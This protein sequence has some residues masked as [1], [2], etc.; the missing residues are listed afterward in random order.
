M[1]MGP[2]R[3]LGALQGS[4]ARLSDG[5]WR[6]SPCRS[7]CSWPPLTTLPATL[8]FRGVGPCQ[9]QQRASLQC[10]HPALTWHTACSSDHTD[11]LGA[12]SVYTAAG[13]AE[14]GLR[15]SDYQELPVTQFC[16]GEDLENT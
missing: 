16:G 1:S 5:V 3:P 9:E 13:R 15:V 2:A 11:Q 6:A 10:C 14:V 8:F 12:P 4:S 7:R